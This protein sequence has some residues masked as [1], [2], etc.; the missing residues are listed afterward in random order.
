MKRETKSQ[1]I[2][3]TT[4]CLDVRVCEVYWRDIVIVIVVVNGYGNTQIFPTLVKFNL[5]CIFLRA[6]FLNIVCVC[7]VF[8]YTDTS[9]T[10]STTSI[11]KY[12]H[13]EPSQ[14]ALTKKGRKSRHTDSSWIVSIYPFSSFLLSFLYVQ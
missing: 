4:F 3:F 6:C 7:E 10:E 5:F 11:R 9:F 14:S 2:A 13:K 1:K 8:G 12:L